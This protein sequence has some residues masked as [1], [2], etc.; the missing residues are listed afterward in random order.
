ISYQDR[1]SI[2]AALTC[3]D[4]VFPEENWEQKDRDIIKNN[5]SIFGMGSDW[6][7]KFD[8]LKPLCEIVY[9]PRTESI[10]TTELKKILNVLNQQHVDDLK[11][12]LDL[13]SGIVGQ[14]G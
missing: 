2:V 9:L 11:K 10:S 3:V 13:I 8:H 7:G 14:F 1:A 5:V 4:E 6:E 12:A